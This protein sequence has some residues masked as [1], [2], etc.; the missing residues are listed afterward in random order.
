MIRTGRG[1]PVPEPPQLL[2]AVRPEPAQDRQPTSPS[3]HRVQKQVIR[4]EPLQVGHLVN[5][6]AMGFWSITDFTRAA[7]ANTPRPVANWVSTIGPIFFRPDFGPKLCSFFLCVWRREGGGERNGVS[8]LE[9]YFF[10]V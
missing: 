3:D 6:P 9:R 7:P 8:R 1:R 4:P 5:G 10:G 2:Q